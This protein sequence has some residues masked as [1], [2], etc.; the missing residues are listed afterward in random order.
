MK[1]DVANIARSEHGS[2]EYCRD[3]RINV[4]ARVY[5]QGENNRRKGG[6]LE[7]KRDCNY[8]SFWDQG[9]RHFQRKFHSGKVL[10]TLRRSS[11]SSRRK[12]YCLARNVYNP[13]TS[14]PGLSFSLGTV[15]FRS[16]SL[17]QSSTEIG[18]CK[19]SNFRRF[20][21]KIF[22]RP[23]RTKLLDKFNL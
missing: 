18:W 8:R 17:F 19:G 15:S 22:F 4:K 13:W 2:R 7:K 1:P 21:L 16:F 14:P 3:I 11:F 23:S 10:V 6:K 12:R 5:R 9:S 20:R